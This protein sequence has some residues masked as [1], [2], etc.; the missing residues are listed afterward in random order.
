MRGAGQVLSDEFH[1]TPQF[2]RVWGGGGLVTA[3]NADNGYLLLETIYYKLVR[4]SCALIIPDLL[5]NT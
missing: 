3:L 1:S 2:K 4:F 5:S